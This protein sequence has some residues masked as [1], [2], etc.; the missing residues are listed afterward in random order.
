MINKNNIIPITK[1]DLLSMIGTILALAGVTYAILKASVAGACKVTGTGDAGNLL[2]DAPVSEIEIADGVTAAVI[3]F[4]PAYNY[5][6]IK[7]ATLAAASVAVDANSAG[8]YKATLATGE[9]TITA[10]TPIAE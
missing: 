3:Y 10:V 9:V 4:V 5:T 6:G 2:A 7:G 8:L 1:M